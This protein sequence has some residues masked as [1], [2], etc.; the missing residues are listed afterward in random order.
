MAKIESKQTAAWGDM[1]DRPTR[2]KRGIMINIDG[3]EGTGKSSLALT[4][5]RIGPVAYAD[6][7]Q[8]ADRA[9][10]PEMPKGKKFVAKVLPIKYRAGIGEEAVKNSCLPAWKL[11]KNGTLEAAKDWAT[12]GV[13]ADTATELWEILRLGV[14]GTLTPQGRT[15]R[16][17]G[18]LNAEFRQWIR[19]ITRHHMRNL[20]MINQM[21]DQYREGNKKGESIRTG[22][23]ER[24]GFKELGYLADM[25]LR[26]YK[27]DG[28]FK[29]R[30][31]MC[32]LAPNGPALEGSEFEG[33]DLDLVKLLCAVTGTEEKDWIK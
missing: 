17:Y 30:I 24:V 28:E 12:G 22:E 8:S 14:F 31:E 1:A 5:A 2:P 15:D 33:D 20:I 32:K 26:T 25:T 13:I 21:K 11:A 18:P 6:S 16:L 29:V 23:L 27:E 3:P 4:A 19:T 7:D 10:R 9:Q